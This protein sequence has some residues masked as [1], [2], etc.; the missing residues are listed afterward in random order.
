MSFARK[1]LRPSK[2][3]LTIRRHPFAFFGLPFVATVIAGSFA[4]SSLTQTRYD[5]RDEKVFSV[6]REEELGMKKGR[7]K[8]DVREEYMVRPTLTTLIGLIYRMTDTPLRLAEA[9]GIGRDR[10]R[11]RLG[12]QARRPPPRSGRVGRAA[13]R[14]EVS[15][16]RRSRASVMRGGQASLGSGLLL[17]GSEDSI[18]VASAGVGLPT[19][20]PLRPQPTTRTDAQEDTVLTAQ[21]YP[22]TSRGARSLERRRVWPRR[23]DTSRE[24]TAPGRRTRGSVRTGSL[25]NASTGSCGPRLFALFKSPRADLR[26]ALTRLTR[27]FNASTL[28]TLRHQLSERAEPLLRRR[29]FFFSFSDVQFQS[30][31][32]ECPRRAIRQVLA[33]EGSMSR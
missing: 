27:S 10:R 3:Q 17:V 30:Q 33:C 9:T 13:R 21:R 15:R 20:S 25:S 22:A 14:E 16:P 5:L 24:R 19:A 7:R 28:A 6:S 18:R 32:A 23:R 31:S 4:L 12:E 1:S 2:L 8:F 26:H 29:D 11:R